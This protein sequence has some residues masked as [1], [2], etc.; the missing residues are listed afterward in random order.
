MH[1]LLPYSTFLFFLIVTT[2]PLRSLMAQTPVS[3]TVV[4]E[5]YERYKKQGDEFFKTGDYFKARQQY[6][7]CL[8]VPGF[9][10]DAYAEG[11]IEKSITGLILNQQVEEA[12]QQGNNQEVLRLYGE[13][14]AFNSDDVRTKARL[15]EYYEREGNQ[16]YAQQKWAEAKDRYTEA[17]K[18]TTRQET[19][20]LQIHN[21][22]ENLKPKAPVSVQKPA[23]HA[24]LKLFTGAV[25]VGASVYGLLLRNN[26]QSKLGALSQISQTVDPNN[27]GIIDNPAG[28]RQY[29]DA[30]A[31][32][33]AAQQKNGLFKAC[34]GV[35]AVA[36]V[37]EIYLLIHQPKPKS[38]VNALRWKPSSQS[39][40]LAVSYTF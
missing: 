30:Y 33:E 19:L 25:A 36:V 16:L 24:G 27:T 10:N 31:A 29:A 11:K 26:Y 18:Y 20:R 17:L 37:A 9:E 34:V 40:G 23:N 32:A 39:W 35:A 13:L 1:K 38:P 2:F 5:E 12:R 22:E 15:A 4:D 21:A 7:N 28:Y 8:E 6:Q 3:T 14:L